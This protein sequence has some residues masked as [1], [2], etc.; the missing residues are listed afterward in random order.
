[1]KSKTIL[2]KIKLS[3]QK[4]EFINP[5]SKILQNLW[6]KNRND[7]LIIYFINIENSRIAKFH[8]LAK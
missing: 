4:T 5:M 6:D 3:H 7:N 1:M 2:W 8:N